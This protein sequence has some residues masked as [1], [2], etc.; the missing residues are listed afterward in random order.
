MTDTTNLECECGAIFKAKKPLSLELL[1]KRGWTSNRYLLGHFI[2]PKC[3]K[4]PR[5]AR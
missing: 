2:C 1:D 5:H 3:Q 4:E